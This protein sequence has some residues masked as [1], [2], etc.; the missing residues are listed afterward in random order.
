[1]N[2][3][4]RAS[5]LIPAILLAAC[6]TTSARD[7][8]DMVGQTLRVEAEGAQPITLIFADQ[9]AV[10]AAIG[11]QQATGTWAVEDSQLCL[12]FPRQGRECWPVTSAF[13]LGE[14]V[15]L[16]SSSGSRARVTRIR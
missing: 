7:R 3:C 12:T 5:V 1:M 14:P 13:R 11:S 16:T 10:S 8:L 2:I 4:I 9:G 6:A 15:T